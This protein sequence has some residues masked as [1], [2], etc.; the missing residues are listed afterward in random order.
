MPGISFD[1]PPTGHE[2]MDDLRIVGATAEVIPGFQRRQQYIQESLDEFP[3]EEIV[4]RQ[5]LILSSQA[6]VPHFS[7]TRSSLYYESGFLSLGR[8]LRSGPLISREIDVHSVAIEFYKPHISGTTPEEKAK[9]ASMIVQMRVLD[10]LF[11]Q[12]VDGPDSDD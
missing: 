6:F 4:D 10:I 1:L 11:C 9:M 12:E 7:D 3:F 2:V 8:A 5:F